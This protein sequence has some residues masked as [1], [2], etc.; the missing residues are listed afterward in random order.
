[1]I[2]AH[3]HFWNFDPVRDAWIGDDMEVLQRDFL[4]EDL[5]RV[6]VRNGVEGVVAVQADQSEKETHFLCELASQ[7]DLIKGVVGWVNLKDKDLEKK[8]HQYSTNKIIKGF[9]HILQAEEAGFMLQPDFISGVRT[10][11]QFDFTYDIL[12]Y[13][14]QL[15]EV[16]QFVDQLPNQ[17]LMIDHCAK[18]NIANGDIVQWEE[19][20]KTISG[21]KNVYCK[22]SG[23]ATEAHW[24]RWKKEEIYPYLDVVMECF[25]NE[26]VVYGSDWPVIYTS[27]SY[28]IWINVLKEYMQQFGRHQQDNFF[29]ENAKRFYNL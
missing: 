20:M 6:A 12:V 19:N 18:P 28:H 24:H 15:P 17:K 27:A 11:K 2:D 1:M 8:L 9:R 23:L 14:D 13:H 21:N 29:S 22:V 3:V 4:P 7:N 16:L 26:R 10:L 25:G 5:E